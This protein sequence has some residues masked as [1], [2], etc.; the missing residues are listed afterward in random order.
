MAFPAHFID[1]VR[2]RVGLADVVGRRVKLSRKGREHSGLCPFHNEKTPSFTLNEDKGFYHCFGCGKH[3]SVFDFVM[4][5]EG[6]N[7]PEA[8]EKLAHEAG[9]Q[10]PEQSPEAARRAKEQAGLHEVMEMAA[11]WFARQLL[12]EAGKGA[13][14][15]I[16]DRG[17]GK[18]AMEHFRMGF[19][20]ESRF[21][22]KQHLT[23]RDIKDEQ[24]IEAG[25]VIK[26]EDG[27]ESY[28]RFRNRLMFPI[29]DRRGRVIAFGG[30]ALGDAKAK[31]LNSPETPLFHK[32]SVLYNLA[33]ARAALRDMGQVVVAEGYMDVI[34]L[35]EGG[36]PY[37][38][39][40]LGTAVTENQLAELWRI[41]PEPIFCLDGDK[42]GWGAAIRAA[43]R[44]LP[45]LKPGHSLKFALLPEGED[46]DTLIRNNSPEAM[47]KL[48]DEALPL[49]EVLWRKTAQGQ[50]M[51]TPE[52]RA[53]FRK[54]IFE[55]VREIGDPTVRGYYEQF[56]T[57]RLD[58]A[59]GG[60]RQRKAGN[61]GG[62]DRNSGFG[63][64]NAKPGGFGGSQVS[65]N[66]A[67]ALSDPGVRR[68]KLLIVTLINHPTLI[69][70]VFDDLVS[71]EIM[72]QELDKLRAEIIDI[73]GRTAPLDR[74]ALKA[75]L[76]ERGQA[77]MVERL[78][79]NKAT[80]LEKFARP[81]ATIEEAESG[82]RELLALDYRNVGLV[83]QRQE[84][85]GTGDLRDGEHLVRGMQHVLDEEQHASSD[86]D[87]DRD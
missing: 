43:E 36:F 21:A 37:A 54:A 57:N 42:A 25:L 29:T 40:P 73:A 53:G 59:F 18:Q 5:T 69:E 78:T 41:A 11:E 51:D 71:L 70:D 12:A 32:G 20:S 79:G 46:P 13:R 61:S 86:R 58:D 39:A 27:G 75:H 31:Y 33:N 49:S 72:N 84:Y 77:S 3:G 56:F 34:A 48:L 1:E 81:E 7:F 35:H 10:I 6:L 19:A 30:R 50:S 62:R 24:L 63:G 44:A 14:G 4:E 2:N 74:A 87:R 64:K 8:V 80:I 38:V 52:R 67:Q 47:Q 16:R 55:T 60:T 23:S 17:V 15:Y 26:P 76:N 28:D 22:L 82:W 45:I 83:K 65:L 66:P 68:V 9:M 85:A